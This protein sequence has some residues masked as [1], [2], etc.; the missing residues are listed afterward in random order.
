MKTLIV[1]LAMVC[2]VYGQT[3]WRTVM[4]DSNG[5]V[6]RPT[7][8]WSIAPVVTVNSNGVIIKPTNFWAV[9]A[10]VSV[11]ANHNM[12]K[13][14]FANLATATSAG[15]NTVISN[16]IVEC[17]IAAT[18]TSGT[19]SVR[20]IA[21]VNDR[22]SSGQGTQFGNNSHTAYTVIDALPRING[23]VRVVL[24][25]STFSTNIAAYPTGHA[26]GYEL[27]N[28]GTSDT[29]RVRLIA[30]NG[31]TATN[32]PWV[33]IGTAFQRFTIGVRQNKTNNIVELIVGVNEATPAINTNATI[34]GGPT[35]NAD[36]GESAF[37]FGLFTTGTN[38]AGI[39]AN[40]YAA[41]VEVQ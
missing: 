18:N 22:G 16:S 28:V 3:N 20:L 23:N 2:G 5:V 38:A 7:N 11:D 4:V 9:N 14:A 33:S 13:T 30:H 19:S 6:Q 15:A 35:G 29:N 41:W 34:S 21:R 17:D 31:T 12:F 8:H 39:N 27:E 26:I 24:G 1:L 32:G 10:P 36:I 25:N 40:V 37:D